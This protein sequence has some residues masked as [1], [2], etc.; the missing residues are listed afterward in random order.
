MK[1]TELLKLAAARIVIEK[2]ANPGVLLAIPGIMGMLGQGYGMYKDWKQSN[3][4]ITKLE[5]LMGVGNIMDSMNRSGAGN[6]FGA[7]PINALGN[8]AVRQYTGQTVDLNRP[9]ATVA[10]SVTTPST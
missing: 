2:T 8:E 4:P 7:G 6:M 5:Q 10:S 9:P 1:S 3:S